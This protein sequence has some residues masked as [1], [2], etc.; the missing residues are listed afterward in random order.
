MGYVEDNDR[1]VGGVEDGEV[2]GIV[3]MLILDARKATRGT[4]WA[5]LTTVIFQI[6]TKGRQLPDRRMQ[7]LHAAIISILDMV[8]GSL[9]VTK[10]DA[11]ISMQNQPAKCSSQ[12]CDIDWAISQL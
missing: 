6:G 4:A 8:P 7:A 2:L 3:S 10:I 9:C 11:G 12:C 1:D 5:S